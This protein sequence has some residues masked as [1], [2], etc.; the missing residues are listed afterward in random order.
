MNFGLTSCEI[1]P[2]FEKDDAWVSLKS[3][4]ISKYK[5]NQFKNYVI[6]FFSKKYPNHFIPKV[7]TRS[8]RTGLYLLLKSL[9]LPK[10][11]EVALQAFSCVV[12][13]NAVLQAGLKPLVLDINPTTYNLDY[14]TLLSQ[15][16]QNIK[17]LIIQHTFGLA[18]DWTDI[19]NFCQEKDIIIIEDCAHSL[20]TFVTVNGKQI[21]VGNIGQASFFS[22]GRDKVVSCTSG[23]LAI[24]KKTEVVWNQNLN[25][26]YSEIKPSTWLES[27][28][29]LLYIFISTL[30]IRPYYGL[31]GKVLFKLMVNFKFFGEV[32]T[33]E[34]KV[35]T[36]KLINAEN[37]HLNLFPVL[38]NQ[39]SK[40]EKFNLHRKEI[41]KIYSQ[42]LGI[43]YQDGSILLRFP[44]KVSSQ[45]YNTVRL[46]L[47]AQNILVGQWYLSPFIPVQSLTSK[48]FYSSK[49][50]PV[51][52]DLIQQKVINLP[53]N[54]NTSLE[55]A[56]KISEVVRPYVI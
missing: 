12:V 33:I 37:L 48:F 38:A 50:C 34:E 36:N 7:F 51:V 5:K 40:L 4:F 19:V 17:V 24:I 41:A 35:G 42:K 21:E 16:N 31:F 28:R 52:E 14:Q 47:K 9:N 23:G 32:Y 25:I 44:V 15:F 22:F 18:A 55:T 3:P 13:P 39:I 6:N 56:L 53:T 2:N 30:L 46:A 1:S 27:I 43:N 49:N 8:S 20:G 54:I 45:N 10:N 11:S 26:L 29:S